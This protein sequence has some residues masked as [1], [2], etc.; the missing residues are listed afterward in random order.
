MNKLLTK[1]RQSQSISQTD[2]AKAALRL[3]A[4]L[5][6]HPMAVCLAALPDVVLIRDLQAKRARA[7]HAVYSAKAA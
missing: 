1:F 3:L 5:D 2:A 4:Y 6:K 7:L